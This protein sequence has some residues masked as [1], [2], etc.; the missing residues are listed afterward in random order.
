MPSLANDFSLQANDSPLVFGRLTITR[1]P[2]WHFLWRG[3][4]EVTKDQPVKLLIVLRL[5]QLV[6]R[7]LV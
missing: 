5:D 1:H 4:A 3:K 7:S 2:H 6:H